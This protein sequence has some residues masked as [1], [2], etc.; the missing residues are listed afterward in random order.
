MLAKISK[1]EH[2]YVYVTIL[3]SSVTQK[4]Y[5]QAILI[6]GYAP[7]TREYGYQHESYRLY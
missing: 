1:A 3:K 5:Y 6:S 2:T 4:L 7:Y